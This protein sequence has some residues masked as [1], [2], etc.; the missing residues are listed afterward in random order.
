M[1]LHGFTTPPYM[2]VS[3]NMLSRKCRLKPLQW[4]NWAF[5]VLGYT[6]GPT[7]RTPLP[8]QETTVETHRRKSVRCRLG[9][10]CPK[11]ARFPS[12]VELIIRG[13]RKKLMIFLA[14]KLVKRD[15]F[16]IYCLGTKGF[17]HTEGVDRRS[18]FLGFLK[19]SNNSKVGPYDSMGSQP[20]WT[21][22]RHAETVV[23]IVNAW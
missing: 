20:T 8:H 14:G 11:S 18:L 1:V 23:Q 19:G 16:C 21:P 5:P 6:S 7:P 22:L 12:S 17:L 4:F 15:M 13:E 10:C 2:R 9:R 3:K